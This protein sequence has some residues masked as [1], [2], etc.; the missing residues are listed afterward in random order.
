MNTQRS[1]RSI[2]SLFG[3]A[4]RVVSRSVPGDSEVLAK[5]PL[6]VPRV[7]LKPVFAGVCRKGGNAYAT[8]LSQ[9]PALSAK[10]R[11]TFLSEA[12]N[13]VDSPIAA[14]LRAEAEREILLTGQEFHCPYGRINI[15]LRSKDFVVVGFEDDK[16]A[17]LREKELLRYDEYL[18]LR[19]SDPALAFFCRDGNQLI[20]TE[21]RKPSR[22]VSVNG[23]GLKGYADPYLW[24]WLRHSANQLEQVLRVIGPYL[25][26]NLAA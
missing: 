10:Y 6:E 16:V 20:D 3:V 22:F 7:V 24:D 26:T 25:S 14:A 2:K 23:D 13:M 17:E 11:R 1:S 12:A 8:V 9:A 19:N 15:F 21:A 5:A 18:R 4:A